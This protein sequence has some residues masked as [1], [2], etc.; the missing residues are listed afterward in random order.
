MAR[1]RQELCAKGKEKDYSFQ[2]EEASR[3]TLQRNGAG[4]LFRFGK[5]I[6]GSGQTVPVSS[7]A[8]GKLSSSYFLAYHV[9][10]KSWSLSSLGSQIYS[11]PKSHLDFLDLL[12]NTLKYP[13]DGITIRREPR[14]R[15]SER[16]L[17]DMEAQSLR[18]SISF[19]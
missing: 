17:L 16:I 19:L 2:A 6:S 4:G 12:V 1:K 14:V 8:S 18:T 13:L 3:T 7:Q 11:F 5:Q 10:I 15:G 9:E